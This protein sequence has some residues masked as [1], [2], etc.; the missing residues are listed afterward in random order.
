MKRVL[1]LIKGLG[2]GGAEQLLAG[3]APYLNRNAFHYQVAYVL[4]WKDALASELHRSRLP[5]RCLGGHAGRGWMRRLRTLVA[6]DRIDLVHAHSPYVAIGARMTLGP[7]TCIVYTEHNVWARYHPA[8]RWANAVTFGRNDHV[9]AVS[10][11]VRASIQ[12]RWLG[13]RC[14]NVE[15]LYHGLAPDFVSHWSGGGIRHE[16]EIEPDA[17]LIVSVAN[18]KPFKGHE[19][20]LRTAA[21]VRRR[22]PGVRF[23]IAGVGPTEPEI[24]R[25]AAD[26]DLDGSVVFAGYRSDAPRL[27][28]S[29]DVFVLPSEHEGLPVA[30][31][32]AMALGRAVVATN[33]GGIPEVVRDGA[34]AVLVGPRDP[35]ALASAIATLLNDP[36]LRDRVGSAARARAAD[37]DIRNAVRRIEEVYE[38]LLS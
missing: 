18:F 38:E 29:A 7:D 32:E 23:V 3:A 30:L 8:T 33:V 24:K 15:T 6:S 16:L 35:E 26:L 28:A 31:L 21:L 11:E 4:P 19:H 5:V 14:P 17:P 20:L 37:F 10:D 13:R 9:F 36:S 1:V 12:S 25:L 2:S 34:D 22:I 27:T